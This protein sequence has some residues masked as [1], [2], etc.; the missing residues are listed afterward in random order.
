MKID[1]VLVVDHLAVSCGVKTT[2]LKFFEWCET[3]GI[4]LALITD[5]QDNLPFTSIRNKLSILTDDSHSIIGLK[6]RPLQSFIKENS[7]IIHND[8]VKLGISH[9]DAFWLD[10]WNGNR[11][12]LSETKERCESFLNKIEP[13]QILI[14][15]QSFLGFAVSSLLN[16]QEASVCFHTNYASVYAIR[17]TGTENYLFRIIESE[18]RKRLVDSFLQVSKTNFLVS[19]TSK[20]FFNVNNTFPYK[21]FTPGVDSSLFKPKSGA[22]SKILRVLFV[23][24]L[25]R[26]N[27]IDEIVELT[28]SI[29]TVIWTIIGN[30]MSKEKIKLPSNAKYLGFMESH[31]LADHMSSSDIFIFYG[32]WDTYGLVALEALSCGVPVL[33]IAKSEIGRLVELNNCGR[34]FSSIEQLINIIKSFEGNRVLLKNLGQNARKFAEK[35]TWDR[36]FLD[37]SNKLGL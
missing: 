34:A 4:S 5:T 17:V 2:Y 6:R 13:K 30:E 15:T 25:S 28:T 35:M 22:L 3:H 1:L 20:Y 23:G 14:A 36:S 33:A 27:G 7:E 12:W 29:S 9:L 24:R 8:L 21:I 37:F 11:C 16:S 19:E 31:D 10:A 32:K 26:E 18:I